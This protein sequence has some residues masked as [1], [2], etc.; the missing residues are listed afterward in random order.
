MRG[1]HLLADPSFWTGV[2]RLVEFGGIYDDVSPTLAP[3]LV[4]AAAMRADWAAVGADVAA[5]MSQ[6][7]NQLTQQSSPMLEALEQ[8]STPML[9][10]IES[11]QDVAESVSGAAETLR[12]ALEQAQ[13]AEDFEKMSSSMTGTIENFRD[14]AESVSG[15]ESVA[16]V[17][18]VLQ[19]AVERVQPAVSS[20]QE[21]IRNLNRVDP[22]LFNQVLDQLEKELL[23][24]EL[25]HKS[26]TEEGLQQVTES[27]SPSAPEREEDQGAAE[28]AEQA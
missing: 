27:R 18:E 12:E 28:K 10:A 19:E 2:S 16:G 6:V 21:Q 17:A 11:F 5:V 22:D 24:E 9:E 7:D 20:F 15:V 25:K 8:M 13:P 23:E 4:D 3:G 26:L 14:V 1:K